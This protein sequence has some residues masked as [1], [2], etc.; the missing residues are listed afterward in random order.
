MLISAQ[1]SVLL[2]IDIQE[3]LNPAMNAPELVLQNA[4]RL[5][6]GADLLNVPTLISEQYPKGLGHAAEPIA[7]LLPE[8]SVQEKETFSCM[9][10]DDYA[11]R[12]NG[13]NKSQAIICGIEAHV[14]VLQTASDLIDSGKK[15]FVVAD[16]T[17][18]RAAA[19][20]MLA[21]ERAK[22]AGAEI[23]TTEMVLFEWLRRAGTPE[24]KEISKLVK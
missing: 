22:T 2:V 11:A 24:F 12:F 13:L 3:R 16:A 23:V 19:N 21:L 10:D 4:E 9:A 7:S 5:L 18:S 14:C 1:Q 8:G 17:S 20:H 6:R 15:V